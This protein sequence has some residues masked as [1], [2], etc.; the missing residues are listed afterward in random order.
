MLTRE[1]RQERFWT[2]SSSKAHSPRILDDEDT[3]CGVGEDYSRPLPQSAAT[4]TEP[5]G[6]IMGGAK[7]CGNNA[8]ELGAWRAARRRRSR[9]RAEPRSQT[10]G[11]RSVV[12]IT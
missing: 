11:A 7:R 1:K 6:K 4:S 3:N 9:G 12:T 5:S 2:Q 8:N 10:D